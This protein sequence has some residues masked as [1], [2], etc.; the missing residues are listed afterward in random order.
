MYS[1][2]IE[3]ELNWSVSDGMFQFVYIVVPWICYTINEHKRNVSNKSSMQQNFSFS[4]LEIY[5]ECVNDLLARN[6]S[7]V[8][9][10]TRNNTLKGNSW[11]NPKLKLKICLLNSAYRL[12][13]PR[14]Y[15]R[16]LEN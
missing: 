6:N 2:E 7:Q 4:F 12:V 15:N 11:S 16:C 1:T 8:N 14:A 13:Q 3:V 10:L 5:N 9:V